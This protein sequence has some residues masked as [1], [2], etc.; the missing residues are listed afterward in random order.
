[1]TGFLLWLLGFIPWEVEAGALGLAALV[2][3]YVVHVPSRHVIWIVG[4]AAVGLFSASLAAKGYS[5]K[6]KEDMNAA[7]KALDRA[8]D[9]RR[10]EEELN[11]DPKKLR[12]PDADMRR[13]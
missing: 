4:L 7:N 1:M 12:K 9:A 6:S 5:V 3:L 11:R 8:A 13:D 10:K 2:L